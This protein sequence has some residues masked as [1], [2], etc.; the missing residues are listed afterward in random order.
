[1]YI[2]TILN[3][4]GR[5]LWGDSVWFPVATSAIVTILLELWSSEYKGQ[6]KTH[7][8]LSSVPLKL[9]PKDFISIWKRCCQNMHCGRI[10]YDKSYFII[11][12]WYR[13]CLHPSFLCLINS[14]ENWST[15]CPHCSVLPL[16]FW[17]L[18][19]FPFLSPIWLFPSDL[20]S[21]LLKTFVLFILLTSL[22]PLQHFTYL[23]FFFG[24]LL[25]LFLLLLLCSSGN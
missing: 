14:L 9:F 15:L 4:F 16:T 10:R 18:V 17:N 6:K 22:K 19:A 13:A 8:R 12:G 1:M 23:E 25:F 7:N 3:N 5:K 20:I 11:S 24:S 2:N 21:T